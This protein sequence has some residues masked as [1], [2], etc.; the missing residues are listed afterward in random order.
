MGWA[1]SVRF[2]PDRWRRPIAPSFSVNSVAQRL[3]LDVM[4]ADQSLQQPVR[5]AQRQGQMA[6]DLADL[7][8]FAAFDQQLQYRQAALYG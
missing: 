2:M 6:G 7:Q 1:A 8:A 3:L 5:G 4:G